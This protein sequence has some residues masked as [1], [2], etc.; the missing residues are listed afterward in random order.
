MPAMPCHAVPCHAML[1]TNACL[2]SRATRNPLPYCTHHRQT[3]ENGMAGRSAESRTGWTRKI[4]RR[5]YATPARAKSI[6]PPTHQA[7]NY[8]TMRPPTYQPTIRP[9]FIRQSMMQCEHC[10]EPMSFLLQIYSPLDESQAFHRMLYVFCCHRGACVQKSSILVRAARRRP[11]TARRTAAS[12]TAASTATTQ[13]SRARMHTHACS[14]TPRCFGASCPRPTLTTA[15][16]RRWTCW[17]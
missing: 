10:A 16:S 11:S 6:P 17:T 8:Q 5:R 3:G 4:C 15:L 2:P 1:A 14:P 9:P 12:T 7:N 13:H